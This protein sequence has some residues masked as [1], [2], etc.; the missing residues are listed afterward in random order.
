M[1]Y[2]DRQALLNQE[3][4][5]PMSQADTPPALSVPKAPTPTQA[6]DGGG[7]PGPGMNTPSQ[8]P[9]EPVTAG[10]DTGPGPGPEAMQLP[11]PGGPRPDGYV[12]N[13]LAQLSNSDTTGTLAQLY[14]MAQQR[15]V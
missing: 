1:G 14:L 6:T 10:V 4:T 8:R 11:G 2:G 9:W 7:Y 13:T 15:G 3:R 5:A 12:T